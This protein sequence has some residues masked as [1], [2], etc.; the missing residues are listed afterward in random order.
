MKIDGSQ[1]SHLEYPIPKNKNSYLF[2]L[3]VEQNEQKRTK[4][5]IGHL[6]IRLFFH[7]YSLDYI[8]IRATALKKNN[9]KNKN[10]WPCLCGAHRKRCI[11]Q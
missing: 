9:N 5:E 6:L 4:S 3:Q 8:V 11:D 2:F 10:Q 7:N 1:R